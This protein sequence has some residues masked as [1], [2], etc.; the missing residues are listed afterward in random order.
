MENLTKSQ[1]KKL[2]NYYRVSLS[3]L[4][5]DSDGVVYIK[6][7]SDDVYILLDNKKVKVPNQLVEYLK[8]IEAGGEGELEFSEE[9]E[10]TKFLGGKKFQVKLEGD[11]VLSF[12]SDVAKKVIDKGTKAFVFTTGS[13][14]NSKLF[15]VDG[16]PV[17]NSNKVP[18]LK[19]AYQMENASYKP[20]IAPGVNNPDW[21]PVKRTEYLSVYKNL[22]TKTICVAVRGTD[23]SDMQDIGADIGIGFGSL[24]VS[25]RYNQDKKVIESLRKVFNPD[26]WWWCAVGHSLGGAIIDELID[27]G[28][29]K[30]GISFNPA[31]QKKHYT[32]PTTN[33]RIYLD[34][35]PLYNLM[36]RFCKYREVRDS[37]KGSLASH[38]LENFIGGAGLMLHA[39]IIKKPIDFPEAKAI[40]KKY[41]SKTFVRETGSS[42]R[43]RNIPKQKFLKESF[44]TKK[45]SKNLSLVLGKLK[46]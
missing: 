9:D 25:L 32:T 45:I 15:G 33:R 17:V 38:G 27:D 23:V 18:D 12:I 24:Q 37:D 34:T 39:V 7:K 11:G 22:V 10:M 1:I 5:V 16:T 35:D 6:T 2:E 14:Y 19:T 41:T 20:D 21:D 29:V 40:A 36:G 31:V 13:L 8:E 4:D 43:F 46:I 44:I 26:D 30:E 42:Y 3:E 28:L